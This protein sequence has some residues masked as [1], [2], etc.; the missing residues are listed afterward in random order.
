MR[1]PERVPGGEGSAGLGLWWAQKP[2]PLTCSVT[3]SLV[4]A[5]QLWGQDVQEQ[6][7]FPPNGGVTCRGWSPETALPAKKLDIIYSTIVNFWFFAY[8]CET[9]KTEG[10]LL[11]ITSRLPY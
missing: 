2:G 11:S 6:S 1:G 5:S 8:L 3:V 4:S 10:A 7:L 9:F